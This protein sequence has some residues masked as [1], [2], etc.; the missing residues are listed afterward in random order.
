MTHDDLIE[1]FI[2][3]L[4]D[5]YLCESVK[6]TRLYINDFTKELQHVKLTDRRTRS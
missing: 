1:L 6:E 3:M 4:A 2:E 5:L